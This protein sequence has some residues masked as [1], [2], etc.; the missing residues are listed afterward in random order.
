MIN[1]LKQPYTVNLLKQYC[2]CHSKNFWTPHPTTYTIKLIKNNITL[3]IWE[4][5]MFSDT[6]SLEIFLKAMRVNLVDWRKGLTKEK[7]E[8][9]SDFIE[10]RQIKNS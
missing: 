6:K 10:K 4:D 2:S 7:I 9:V 5:S 1:L 8:E 3:M